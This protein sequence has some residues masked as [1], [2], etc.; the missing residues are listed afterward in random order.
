MKLDKEF[1]EII[2]EIEECFIILKDLI[3]EEYSKK[4]GYN[5]LGYKIRY[6]SNDLLFYMRALRDKIQNE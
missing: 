3:H 4:Y 6:T 1:N 5:T 2:F